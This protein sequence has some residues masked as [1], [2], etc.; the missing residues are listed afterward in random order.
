MLGYLDQGVERMGQMRRQ[1]RQRSAERAYRRGSEALDSLKRARDQLRDP[2]EQIRVL[3]GEVAGVARAT[4]ALATAAG[5]KPADP[6]T[7][8]RHRR[9]RTRDSPRS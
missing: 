2:V 3:I 5:V 4:E 9:T 8:A 1:L 7:G 6:A